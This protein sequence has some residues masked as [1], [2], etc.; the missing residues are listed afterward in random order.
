MAV[1]CV[2][3]PVQE[4]IAGWPEKAAALPW[5]E[6]L[7]LLHEGWRASTD[8]ANWAVRECVRH[9]VT[10]TPGQPL[11]PM[12]PWPD[13]PRPGKKTLKG[14]YGRAVATL[15]LDDPA[16]PWKGVAICAS[17]LLRRVETKWRSERLNVLAQGCRLP[18]LYRYPHPYPV[19]ATCWGAAVLPTYTTSGGHVLQDV[20]VIWC[21][22]PGGVRVS[23]R[24][25]GGPEFARHLALFRRIAS[26]ELKQSELLLCGQGATHSARRP[27]GELR[28]PGGGQRRPFRVMVRMPVKV[29]DVEPRAPDRVLTLETDPHCLWVA[30]LDGRPCWCVN[31]DHIRRFLRQTPRHQVRCQRWAEDAKAER[32]GSRRKRRQFQDARNRAAAKYADRM[33]SWTNEVASH[34]TRFAV[35]CKVT[36]VVYCDD[37]RGFLDGF[38]WDRLHTALATSLS[39]VGIQLES[40][41]TLGGNGDGGGGGGGDDNPPPL[42]PPGGN[43]KWQQRTVKELGTA[44]RKVYAHLGRKSSHP[45]VA[46]PPATSATYSA[47]SSAAPS[48]GRSKRSKG[49]S[50]AGPAT[51]PS[52]TPSS[53]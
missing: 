19:H 7:R 9:D 30:S 11:P 25:R 24:L 39:G 51:A 16:S 18:P 44:A 26:G 53:R 42:P 22:M 12:P 5:D 4:C 46:S 41:T 36:R 10:H 6:F 32:R 3:L 37:D 21:K 17:S 47:S 48:R 2:S 14:L 27:V 1:R 45:A 43:G 31:E 52:A 49:T 40:G 28:T 33:K 15:G 38:P 34:L 35:R 8:L 29:P 20:P 23:L 50:P 13:S